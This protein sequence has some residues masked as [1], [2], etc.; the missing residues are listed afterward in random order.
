MYYS[1][2]HVESPLGRELARQ[3][4]DGLERLAATVQ[5]YDPQDRCGF[6]AILTSALHHGFTPAQ[7]ADAFYVSPATIGRWAACKSVPGAHSRKAIVEEIR[8]MIAEDARQS[9]SRLAGVV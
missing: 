6:A 9:R 5:S 3:E 7:L 4:I 2:V 1:D 8:T